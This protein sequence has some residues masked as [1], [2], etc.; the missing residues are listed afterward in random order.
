MSDYGDYADDEF[1]FDMFDSPQYQDGGG[2]PGKSASQ[3]LAFLKSIMSATGLPLTQLLGGG[4]THDPVA[5]YVNQTLQMY[6]SSPMYQEAFGSIEAGADPQT[7]MKNLL[8]PNISKEF[9]IDPSD[10]TTTSRIY[11]TLQ[12]YARDRVQG[13]QYERENVSEGNT[14]TLANGKKYNGDPNIMGQAS[15]YDLM[16]RQDP[17]ELLKQFAAQRA[18]KYEAHDRATPG[19]VD[20]APGIQRLNGRVYNDSGTSY[21]APLGTPGYGSAQMEKDLQNA[22]MSGREL[23]PNSSYY[24]SLQSTMKRRVEQSKTNM[25][26]SDANSS[27]M[28]NILALRA[29]IGM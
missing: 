18:T 11:D 22:P 27:A 14:F 17:Q 7:V 25:V 26:R 29:L 8:D 6:G 10:A 2:M 28:R 23:D 21:S 15:E 24:K 13:R 5:P 4:V 3:K 19:G 12:A 1:M 9:G 16:G 20:L